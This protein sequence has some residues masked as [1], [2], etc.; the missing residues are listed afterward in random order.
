M[1]TNLLIFIQSV[2]FFYWSKRIFYAVGPFL[3]FYSAHDVCRGIL[4]RVRMVY[5]S[6]DE[7]SVQ[8]RAVGKEK[9]R[10]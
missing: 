5:A 1:K 2:S 4:S 6:V 10:G 3:F 7:N 9:N 8:G